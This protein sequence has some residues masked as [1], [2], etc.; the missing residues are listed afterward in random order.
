MGKDDFATLSELE[1]AFER[2]DLP[3]FIS[4][5]AR[6]KGLPLLLRVHAVCMLEHIGDECVVQPLC[7][8]LKDDPSPLSRHEAAFTLRQLGYRSAA[9]AFEYLSYLKRKRQGS[10]DA[11]RPKIRL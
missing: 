7:K 1:E 10:D 11:V 8:I 4:L 9:P 6:S 3:H 5:L 2:K